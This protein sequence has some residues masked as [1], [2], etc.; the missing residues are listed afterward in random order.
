MYHLL[1]CG[2]LLSALCCFAQPANNRI[3]LNNQ[4]ARE[5]RGDNT[6]SFYQSPQMNRYDLKYLKLD[7]TVQ[8]PGRAISGSCTYRALVKQSLDTFVLE[9]RDH[10]TVDSVF[11]NGTR[12]VF[13]RSPNH[14]NTIVSPSIPAG[15]TIEVTYFY[16]GN[17]QN[18]IHSGTNMATGLTYLATVSE[19]FQAREWFP[20]KQVLSDKIDSAEIWITTSDTNLVGS[21]GLLQSTVNLPG[22]MR[23]YRWATR[24]PMAYYLVS[25]AA[26]N[27]LSYTN[28]AKPRAMAPDSVP[29]L[30]YL[31][32]TSGYFAG[33]KGQLDKTPPFLEKMS[34]LFGLYPFSREK[35]GHSQAFIGGG[36]E[37]Q[38]MTTLS[39]FD[40]HLVAHEL[41][42]QWFGDNVT[43]ATWN[44]I[45]LNESFAT[46]AQVLMQEYLQPLFSTTPA[47]QMSDVHQHIMSAPGGSVYIA[48]QDLYDE[49]RIFDSRLS[50]NKGSAVL[51]T[52]RFELQSDTLFFTILKRYQQRYKDSVAT[53][54]HFKKIAEEVSGRDLTTF[55]NQWI[56]GEGFPEYTVVYNRKGTDSLV[57]RVSQTS[58]MPAVTPLFQ[59]LVEFRIKS[60]AGDTLVKL[61]LT[62]LSQTFKIPY[63][64]VPSGLEVDPFNWIVNK[65]GTIQMGEPEQEVNYLSL[66][67]SPNPAR[68]LVV[69][70]FLPSTFSEIALVDAAGRRLYTRKVGATET[71]SSIPLYFP[72]GV[73]FITAWSQQ[74]R[75]TRK[76][77]IV[78]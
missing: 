59:G 47:K 27:Y 69:A 67:L 21:N 17:Q 63:R 37:H 78:R 57:I 22:N 52:L 11:V 64:K 46:Y 3:F 75:Q 29:I 7:F 76:L 19:S 44:D 43:C 30:H 4:F 48:Q 62:Q 61:N 38:T 71:V 8:P 58:S 6:A 9:L 70:R 72:P 16:R 55:F 51:H 66:Q 74:E 65:T 10:L 1:T 23:Q 42:H 28:Y 25:Y 50:Y 34:E 40:D 60:D 32:K 2:F 77:V 39:S 41:A 24:Y 12:R 73:Y 35:Y 45:W 54:V 56:Y 18:G 49:R 33:V 20:A 13:D 31:G 14:I 68:N 26:A 15:A 5:V 53:T 36:M